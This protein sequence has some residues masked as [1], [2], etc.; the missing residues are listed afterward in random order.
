MEQLVC[1]DPLELLLVLQEGFLDQQTASADSS[2]R[3][4]LDP[5]AAGGTAQPSANH[6][7]TGACVDSDRLSVE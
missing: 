5:A 2:R 3:V 1:E 4:D 6:P 7:Q